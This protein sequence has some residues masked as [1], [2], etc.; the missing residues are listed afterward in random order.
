[1]EEVLSVPSNSVYA[2]SEWEET[3]HTDNGAVQPNFWPQLY[4]QAL[5]N[6]D[7]IDHDTSSQQGNS[8]ESNAAL[9]FQPVTSCGHCCACS[10]RQQLCGSR[11]DVRTQAST[12]RYPRPWGQIHCH[13]DE[14]GPKTDQNS[15]R[16]SK[17]FSGSDDA[18]M[19][20]RS[21]SGD[22]E[23]S[24][25]TL[26]I[27]AH[28]HHPATRQSKGSCC[29]DDPMRHK[30][31][32]RSHSFRCMEGRKYACAADLQNRY[33]MWN[34]CCNCL[35]SAFPDIMIIQEI[36]SFLDKRSLLN[37]A[38]VSRRWRFLA[39]SPKLWREVR[40]VISLNRAVVVKK[41]NRVV[42]ILADN[43]F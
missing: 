9:Y 25:S 10:A 12:G 24:V 3:S 39:N 26:S 27:L 2:G 16:K 11:A 32:A 7:S 8:E 13:S 37:A 35:F 40:L 18:A 19:F 17:H 31:R 28:H 34:P 33:A 5:Q 41:K 14:H 36:F 15:V 6:D 22:S 38:A 42:V 20:S 43:S 30:G 4:T 29:Q 23:P 21:K 1:M